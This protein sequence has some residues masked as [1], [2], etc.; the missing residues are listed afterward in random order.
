M[1]LSGGD[2]KMM[3][4]YVGNLSFKTTEDQL[5]QAFEA[6]GQVSSAT[7]VMDRDTGRPRGFGFVEMTNDDEAR[8]A[9]EALNGKPLDGRDLTVNEARPREAG[10][11]GGSRGGFGGGRGGGGGSRGGFGGGGGGGGGSRGGSGGSW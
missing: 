4:L 7:V 5:R 8:A 11:G 6:H 2:R 3:K 9:V 1:V 10:G